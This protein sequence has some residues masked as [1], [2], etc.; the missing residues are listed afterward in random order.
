MGA[1]ICS[2]IKQH[3]WGECLRIGCKYGNPIEFNYQYYYTGILFTCYI[4]CFLIC[5]V[6]LSC[7]T[8]KHDIGLE[9]D[10][11][12]HVVKHICYMYSRGR[13]QHNANQGR[14]QHILI[15]IGPFIDVASSIRE[16]SLCAC[17]VSH[18]VRMSIN[19]TIP[20]LCI[21]FF[22]FCAKNLK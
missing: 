11:C 17:D 6:F 10:S 4:F 18:E 5:I 15:R 13:L 9:V 1:L 22:F 2:P 3:S 16:D 7:L 21:S 19:T 12:I 14:L 20:Y 8:Q